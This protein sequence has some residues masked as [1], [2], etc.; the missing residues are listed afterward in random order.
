MCRTKYN[1]LISTKYLN[2]AIHSIDSLH[3]FDTDVLTE[4]KLILLTLVVQMD[5]LGGSDGLPRL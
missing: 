4:V 3:V 1:I 5:Y 2:Y